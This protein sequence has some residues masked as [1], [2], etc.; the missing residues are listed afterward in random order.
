MFLDKTRSCLKKVIKF[1][2]WQAH[3]DHKVFQDNVVLFQYN[4]ATMYH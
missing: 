3:G 4:V 2:R 1:I